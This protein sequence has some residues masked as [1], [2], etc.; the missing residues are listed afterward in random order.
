MSN[1]PENTRTMKSS[2]I[3]PVQTTAIHNSPHSLPGT[4][5]FPPNNACPIFGNEMLYS[6][7]LNPYYNISQETMN[8]FLSTHPMP[9]YIPDYQK[10]QMN[11]H[12][13]IIE[14]QKKRLSK[15]I[16]DKRTSSS[17]INPTCP[18]I[19][20][21]Q[22]KSLGARPFHGF[23]RIESREYDDHY[24]LLI[25]LPGMTKDTIQI[26][27]EGDV[28][29]VSCYRPEKVENAK[30]KIIYTERMVGEFERKFEILSDI[31]KDSIKGDYRNGVLVID[32]PKKVVQVKTERKK[33]NLN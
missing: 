10:Y 7:A 2:D 8:A 19:D 32:F 21:K 22:P 33:I 25:D 1:N 12:S 23:G 24:S 5:Q 17:T 31:D 15:K 18:Y 28:L 13:K 6:D 29:I 30:Y 20:Q 16:S 26:E 3:S 14:D 11:M 4:P 27:I 9:Q